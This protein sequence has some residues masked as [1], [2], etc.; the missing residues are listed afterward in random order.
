[1]IEAIVTYLRASLTRKIRRFFVAEVPLAKKKF[2]LQ[3]VT[4]GDLNEDGYCSVESDPKLG[5]YGALPGEELT[6][7]PFTRRQRRIFARP[8]EIHTSHIDRVQPP[9]SVA[10][11]CGG[12]SLQHLDADRQIQ[13][14]QQFVKD[15]FAD[16]QPAEWFEPLRGDVFNY[17]AK[18][19]LGVKFVDKK[20]KV[21]VGFREQLK[22]FIVETKQCHVLRE[23]VGQLIPDLANLVEGLSI[24]RELPQIEV[25]V[26]EGVVAFV[27]RHLADLQPED[28]Q[29]LVSF[30]K[31]HSTEHQQIQ[32]YLQPN[33]PEVIHRIYPETGSDYLHYTLEQFDLKFEFLPLD[34]TQVNPSINTKMVAKAVELLGLTSNDQVFDAFCGIGNFSLALAR[35]AG[36]V[37][38]IEASEQSVVRARHN[39][40]LNGINNCV[41]MA[42]NLFA[43]SPEIQ[44]LERVNKVLLDPPRS[45]AESLC[46]KL[47]SHKV[48]RVVYVSCNPVSLARDAKILV[49]NGYKF[50]GAGVIDMFPHT[51]H[52][53]SIASFSI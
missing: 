23:P 32:M 8:T 27:F 9:C 15:T 12:C 22:P 26:S 41:F 11:V 28:L 33:P 7:M 36:H 39:A 24:P 43:E 3:L 4:T 34:F 25:A 29:A 44:G 35:S 50:D 47:A 38:G 19:R 53:E 1:M 16:L 37:L 6:V 14:K 2:S 17:R 30:A 31:K 5:V 20:Q 51:T 45:G 42:Q 13:F 18:G 10:D 52:V 21:L 46:K 40:D 48:E 49:A